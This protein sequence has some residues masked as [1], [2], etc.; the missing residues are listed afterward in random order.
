M[1]GPV[2]QLARLYHH[3][4]GP[5]WLRDYPRRGAERG[6]QDEQGVTVHAGVLQ[7]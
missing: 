2:E 3:D 1:A 5:G 7:L 4:A 6:E